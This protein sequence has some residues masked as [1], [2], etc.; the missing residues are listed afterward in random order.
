MTAASGTYTATHIHNTPPWKELDHK[1]V[2][3]H[4]QLPLAS[5]VVECIM[6]VLLVKCMLIVMHV[7]ISVYSNRV[8]M[9]VGDC[10]CQ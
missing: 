3:F 6:S 10:F 5:I 7:V 4:F 1:S 8:C 9:A 2:F